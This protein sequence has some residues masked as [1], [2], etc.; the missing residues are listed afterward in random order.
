MPPPEEISPFDL[1]DRFIATV[2]FLVETSS[3]GHLHLGV[4]EAGISRHNGVLRILEPN[5]F[6]A[7]EGVVDELGPIGQRER[8]ALVTASDGVAR[9]D[10]VLRPP[11]IRHPRVVG[12][13]VRVNIV[14][15]KTG[16]D[17]A[18]W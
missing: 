1:A 14:P 6:C 7:F 15:E 10:V 18:C 16:N 13:L 2:R 8:D 3:A 9:E 5:S 11:R 17:G 4:V 12:S